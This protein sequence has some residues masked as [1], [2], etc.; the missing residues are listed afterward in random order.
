MISEPFQTHDFTRKIRQGIKIPASISEQLPNSDEQARGTQHAMKVICHIGQPKTATTLL[1]N[2]CMENRSWLRKH[3]VLYPDTMDPDG[4]HIGLLFACA[5]YVPVFA[6]QRG[7]NTMDDIKSF[8][9]KLSAHLK[10]QIHEAGDE[11]HT[12]L[13]SSEN[14]TANIRDQPGVQN[15]ADFLSEIFDEIQIVIYLRRQDDSLLSMYGEYMRRGFANLSFDQFMEDTLGNPR[16]VPYIFF[17]RIISLWLNALGKEQ[18]TV[19]IFDRESL[20]GSDISNDFFDIVFPT[21]VLDFSNL[22]RSAQDNTGLSAPALEFLRRLQP[23]IPFELNGTCNQR[24]EELRERIEKLPTEPR[25]RLSK[26]QSDHI[27]NHFSQ[28]NEWVR[29]TFLPDRA[30]PLFPTLHHNDPTSNLGRISVD[31]FS[32][33]TG[34][35]LQSPPAHRTSSAMP[36]PETSYHTLQ[37]LLWPELEISTERNLYVKLNGIAAYAQS[38]KSLVFGPGGEADFGTAANMFNLGKWRRHCDLSDLRLRL[39]GAGKFELVVYQASAERSWDRLLNDVIELQ[40]GQPFGVD[41]APLLRPDPLGVIFFRLRAI[42]EGRLI[43]AIW[44]TRQAPKREPKLVLSITT[45]KR[46]EAVQASVARFEAFMKTTHLAP[47][48]HLVVVDNGRSAEV[49]P[50]AH[51]TLIGNENLGGSG[52]F[53]RGLLETEARGASHCLFMDDDASVHM[54]ALERVWALLAYSTASNTAV[55]G[56]LLSARHRWAVW[57]SGAIFDRVCRP[58]YMGTDLR[59]IDQVIKMECASTPKAPFN[60]YGGWWFFAF[61]VEHAKYRPFPFFVRGDDVSFSIVNDFDIVTLPG[62]YSS[63]DSDFSDKETLQTRYLD[64]RSHLAHHLALPTMDIGRFRTLTIPAWFFMSS[65]AQC[66][67]ETL[68]TINLAV[69][70]VLRG[71]TFFA[72][73]ADMADRRAAIGKIRK[74]ETWVPLHGAPPASKRRF[75]PRSNWL[76]RMVMKYSLNG[77]LLPFFGFWGNRVTLQSDQRGQLHEAWGAAQITYI[78]REGTQSFTVRHSKMAA[79]KQGIRMLRNGIKLMRRYP[80]IKAEWQKGYT[81]LASTGFWTSRLGM[82]SQVPTTSPHDNT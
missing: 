70:D 23:Y 31:E 40:Q 81:E 22:Q 68:A 17:R 79:L 76:L 10:R 51:I 72:A 80:K 45:F 34:L 14:L 53:A 2:T 13:L 47:H 78:N 63:Q 54:G 12:V 50:S 5:D 37:T 64:L 48:L 52:G 9:T 29:A 7:I 15:V 33:F 74:T 32:Q 19:R 75:D 16:I 21:G 3:G 60:L 58:L 4:N 42:G 73:N 61:P 38:T 82:E 36:L 39:E 55:A 35:L 46:E 59:D 8:R 56:A 44:Q 18:I 57:E 26:E 66:H 25:P 77:H 27:M 62:V 24:R 69:E 11:I 28:D 1:Q 65:L 30:T 6:R 20:V 49:A 43:T 71:P 67:Y 41:L